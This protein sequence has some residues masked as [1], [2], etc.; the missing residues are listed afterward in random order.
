M[1]RLKLAQFSENFAGIKKSYVSTFERTDLE[2]NI[3][4]SYQFHITYNKSYSIWNH[5]C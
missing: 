2:K 4:K 1:S 5:F 3:E